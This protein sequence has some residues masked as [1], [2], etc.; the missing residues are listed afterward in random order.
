MELSSKIPLVV[1]E[2]NS[3]FVLEGKDLIDIMKKPRPILWNREGLY[4]WI[5]IIKV[6][7]AIRIAEDRIKT[8]INNYTLPSKMVYVWN[9]KDSIPESVAQAIEE[10]SKL[11]Q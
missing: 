11:I 8:A 2:K 1:T 3:S 7:N 5:S 10:M 4:G 9:V 6:R